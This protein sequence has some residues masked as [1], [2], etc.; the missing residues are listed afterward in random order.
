[1]LAVRE[2]ADP[3]IG[4]RAAA[5]GRIDPWR[6]AIWF[7]LDRAMARE[8]VEAALARSDIVLADRSFYSTLAYQGSALAPRAR[9]R[10]TRMQAD[11]ARR[12]DLA[13]LLDLDP[14]RALARLDRRGKARAPLERR[15]V[16]DRVARAY[17]RLARGPGWLVVDASAPASEIA[18]AVDQAVSG[19]L[20]G[21]GGRPRERNL[22][23]PRPPGR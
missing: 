3:W 19:L 5:L 9:A 20:G 21:R 10:L 16:L 12:P 11:A 6:S 23:G 17:R 4:A 14:D 15:A 2:P 8:R 13:V 7:T 18:Q 1:V 22:S